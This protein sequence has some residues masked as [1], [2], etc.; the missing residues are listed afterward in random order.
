MIVFCT[1]LLKEALS[2]NGY[3]MLGVFVVTGLLIGGVTLM[4]RLSSGKQAK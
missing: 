1:E 4:N 2:I 3:G